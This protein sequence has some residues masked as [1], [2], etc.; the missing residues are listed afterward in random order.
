[1]GT[2]ALADRIP[3]FLAIAT[4]LVCSLLA[5]IP[6]C[7]LAEC[8]IHG[9]VYDW[10]TFNTVNNAIVDVYSMPD[11]SLINHAVAKSGSYSFSLPQGSYMI[12]A[13]VGTPGTP[14]EITA[15]ENITVPGTGER[16]IDL[17]LFPPDSLDGLTGF[18]DNNA[19]PTMPPVESPT[20]QPVVTPQQGKSDWSLYLGA[21]AILLAFIAIAAGILFLRRAKSGRGTEAPAAEENP[22]AIE[23]LYEQPAEQPLPPAEEP[24]QE[25]PEPQAP[26]VSPVQPQLAPP[27]AQELLLP[28]DCREVLAIME[29]NGGRITQLDLRKALP[30]SEAKVSLIVSDLESRGLVKKIKKGRGNVLILNR[31]GERPPE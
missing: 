13:T 10:S 1:M 11:L 20:T 15:T 29:K 8:T 28:Q 3:R 19:T 9:N 23:E 16:T 31:P 5:L 26:P 30:Y 27:S 24:E 2:L 7:A 6:A 4:I 18:A 21:G 22:A 14:D 12:K 17:V 25:P